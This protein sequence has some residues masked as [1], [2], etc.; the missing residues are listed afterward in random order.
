MATFTATPY[1]SAVSFVCVIQAEL[2]VSVLGQLQHQRLDIRNQQCLTDFNAGRSC[3]NF[4]FH[5]SKIQIDIV[6]VLTVFVRVCA[7]LF[8]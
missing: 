2:A 4:R 7:C 8:V 6:C 3:G 5:N 1:T